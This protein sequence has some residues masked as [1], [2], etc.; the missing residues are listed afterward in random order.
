MYACRPLTLLIASL[1]SA[2]AESQGKKKTEAEAS[3]L[4]RM[5]T[6][7]DKH[8]CM[9]TPGM[10]P[11]LGSHARLQLISKKQVVAQAVEQL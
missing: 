3:Y 6:D 11:W 7:L 10:M 1:S 4:K 9:R 8:V 2:L 5:K